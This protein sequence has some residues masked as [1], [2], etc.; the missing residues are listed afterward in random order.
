MIASDA[1]S[2][3][4]HASL[5]PFAAMSS[6][7]MQKREGDSL[8]PAVARRARRLR[9]QA[10]L[11]SSQR[12]RFQGRLWAQRV[13][14]E[15]ECIFTEWEVGASQ[16]RSECYERLQGGVKMT[17]W[18]I[19]DRIGT[20]LDAFADHFLASGPNYWARHGSK[21]LRHES[22]KSLQRIHWAWSRN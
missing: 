3:L 18:L 14:E 20:N 13:D 9:R 4:C 2:R 8:S 5:P 7:I 12:P 6:P 19:S 15:A 21:A 10:G 17:D 22:R 1:A 16:G 11:E